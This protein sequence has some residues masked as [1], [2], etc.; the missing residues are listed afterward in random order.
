MG[1]VQS[2]NLITASNTT[3]VL[4]IHGE[5]DTSVSFNTGSPFNFSSFPP[6]DGSNPI[7]NKLNSLGFNNH[8]L[9]LYQESHMSF[10]EQLMVLGVMV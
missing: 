10:T 9:T 8:E 7:N 5:A 3:P 6:A 4:L 2:T 1:A